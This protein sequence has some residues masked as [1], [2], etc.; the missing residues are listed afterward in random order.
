MV[1]SQTFKQTAFT[2]C[3]RESSLFTGDVFDMKGGKYEN[4]DLR[5]YL[6]PYL[7]GPDADAK[8]DEF[9]GFQTM[10]FVSRTKGK[11]V[12]L[13]DPA[14]L[15]EESHPLTRQQGHKTVSSFKETNRLWNGK[16]VIEY[17]LVDCDRRG[18]KYLF[19][20]GASLSEAT[21][22][23]KDN[24]DDSYLDDALDTDDEEFVSMVKKRID[25][26]I[27]NADKGPIVSG[28]TL[29]TEIKILAELFK[30][31]TESEEKTG[32]LDPVMR[33]LLLPEG[34][35]KDKPMF[36]VAFLTNVMTMGFKAVFY[37]TA[38]DELSF[39]S[40]RGRSG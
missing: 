36:D 37:P 23:R 31:E 16:F 17:D 12:T 11:P 2:P 10:A 32:G 9:G 35:S 8:D 26:C 20:D 33:K 34:S 25:P 29:L 1:G 24:E 19:M 22:A 27:L 21:S 39:S 38:L 13:Y 30:E 3:S 14:G 4:Q 5:L 28:S 7:D 15:I 18:K 6:I 40:E